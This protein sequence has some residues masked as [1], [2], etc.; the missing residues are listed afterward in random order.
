MID[1]NQNKVF[2]HIRTLTFGFFKFI[3]DNNSENVSALLSPNLRQL[4]V[5]EQNIEKYKGV[6]DTERKFVGIDFFGLNQ[7]KRGLLKGIV[8]LSA[9][10]PN[11][12]CSP[13]LD[14]YSKEDL[15]F[16]AFKVKFIYIGNYWYVN[17]VFLYNNF[18]GNDYKDYRPSQ[19]N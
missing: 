19:S 15:Q 18:W 12:R 4:V 2:R 14:N 8:I 13:E 17:D 7:T 9:L 16:Y 10:S 1:I 6:F 3:H 11:V 5:I